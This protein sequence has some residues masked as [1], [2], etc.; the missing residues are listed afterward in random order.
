MKHLYKIAI[1]LFLTMGGLQLKANAPLIPLKD[2]FK[3]PKTLG[4]KI[5]PDGKNL[6]FLASYKN[7]L[8]VFVQPADLS[9]KPKR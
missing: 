4:Y 8:N 7:R 9:S 3:N 6:S 1:L 2:F 5:S